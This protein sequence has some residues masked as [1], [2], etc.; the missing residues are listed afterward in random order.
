[1]AEGSQWF[2]LVLVV[3]IRSNVRATWKVLHYVV[4]LVFLIPDQVQGLLEHLAV[5]YK[6][7]EGKD[8]MSI[9]PTWPPG[10]CLYILSNVGT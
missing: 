1:M 3:D 4:P 10:S 5:L 8:S 9:V 6:L 7:L 2:P